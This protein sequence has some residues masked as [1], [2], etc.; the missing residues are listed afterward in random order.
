MLVRSERRQWRA[1]A[2]R[3]GRTLKL[4]NPEYVGPV[5]TSN[6]TVNP[7]LRTGFKA[8]PGVLRNSASAG[9]GLGRAGTVV[10][11]LEVPG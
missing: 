9:V 7:D 8:I 10:T 5:N 11:R 4:T 1:S 6:P 3:L 2:L